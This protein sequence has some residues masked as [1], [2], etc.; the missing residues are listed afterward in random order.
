MQ[1]VEGH[2]AEQRLRLLCGDEEGRGG[3]RED[4]EGG[5]MGRE[6]GREG[7][8]GGGGGGGGVLSRHSDSEEPAH[9]ETTAKRCI[10]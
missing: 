6:G 8:T 10:L 9:I 2:L 4:G 1:S 3:G 5:R 7:G